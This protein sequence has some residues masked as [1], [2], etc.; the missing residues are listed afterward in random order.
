MSE[1][2]TGPPED[3]R[4]TAFE[5]PSRRTF[6]GA[7]AAG[8]SLAGLTTAGSTAAA[9]AETV[10][11]LHDTHTHSEIG[12]V[13]E[14][15]NIATYRTKLEELFDA[16]S[17]PM[18][19]GN[20][21]DL[22]PSI[23]S[24][25]S[26]GGHIIDFLNELPLTANAVG[27]HEFDYGEENAIEQFERSSFTWITADLLTEDEEPIPNTER[28]VI[29]EQNGIRVGLFGLAPE[30]ITGVTSFPESWVE[31]DKIEAAQEATDALIEDGAD[32]VVCASHT[33]SPL[34]AQIAEAV[35]GLDAIV[36]SHWAIEMDEP[37]VVN[38]TVISEVG[39]EFDY[40]GAVEL[41][42]DGELVNWERH[43]TEEADEHP[44]FVDMMNELEDD[45]DEELNYV[46]G[47]TEYEL[48]TDR[49]YIEA[50]E[51]RLGNLA[52]DV[53]IDFFE[54]AEIS[55]MNEGAFRSGE[56]YGPGE[57]TARDW[58][59]VF[60]FGNPLV[61]FEIDGET[62]HE[63]LEHRGVLATEGQAGRPDQQVGGLQFEWN[64]HEGTEADI[65]GEGYLDI[66]N[67]YVNGE[68]LD[69]DETYMV[70][71]D[72]WV[73]EGDGGYA[74]I[75]DLE[76]AETSDV[77]MA[78]AMSQYFEEQGTVAPEIDHRMLRFDE[79][80]GEHIEI[81][82]AADAEVTLIYEAPE[83]GHEVHAE[84]Y[85]AVTE[86]GESADAQAVTLEDDGLEVT[87]EREALE[88]LAASADDV[89]LRIFG[90]IT[91]DE[92]QFEYE[93]PGTDAWEYHVVRGG[94]DASVFAA[95][96]EAEA[97]GAEAE[98]DEDS[99]PGFGVGVGAAGVAGGAYA[100]KKL[101]ERSGG[102]E[103]DSET[104]RTTAES[105]Q[106]R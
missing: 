81:D 13:G 30:N 6:L 50:R 44:E 104:G 57:V 45:L 84:S 90:G 77:T 68:P 63:T 61:R 75:H 78:V 49:T 54:E 72:E 11:I 93:V 99:I 52:C 102:P 89:D 92:A 7:T 88:S 24:L 39:D 74:P 46:V 25:F 73:K 40:I 43:A 27:N 91:P 79:D 59:E 33:D 66:D 22:G 42:A 83:T 3:C 70:A 82:D 23:Y 69:P 56:A 101:S 2:T 37:E 48:D 86:H 71:C 51:T 98:A 106:E 21:D 36:G 55:F 94:V 9:E 96:G 8:L 76:T 29:E 32:V 34:H 58:T 4:Q 53:L 26:E 20:G 19:V 105:G 47:E 65:H 17:N 60:A 95:D 97:E 85:Y 87:F 12:E 5:E 28:W 62:L 15:P 16:E 100:Y 10:T 80:V 18:F 35:D 41:D 103:S 31:L 1:K 38:G 64:P 67:V 14:A